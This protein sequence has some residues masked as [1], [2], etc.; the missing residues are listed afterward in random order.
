[1]RHIVVLFSL[2]TLMASSAAS[3]ERQRPP[4]QQPQAKDTIPVPRFRVE[5]PVSPLAALGRSM[6]LP[7][8]GQAVLGRRG[9]GAAFVFWEG[10]TLA[11]TIKSA[12]QLNFQKSIDAETVDDKRAEFQDWLVLLVFNHLLAGTEAYVS[13]L[14]WDFP[15]E[16]EARALPEGQ[17]GLGMSVYW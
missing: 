13:A 11:M 8:W 7:G 4:Q 6:L 15:T 16:L 14:L 3:Q 17:V 5:P 10:L 12:H 1:M 9:V 2:L